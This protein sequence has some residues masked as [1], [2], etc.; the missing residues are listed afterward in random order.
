MKKITK[1]LVVALSLALLIGAVVG[2]SASATETGSEK[3]VISYN[4]SYEEN[5][6]LYFAVDANSVEDSKLLTANVYAADGSVLAEGITTEE[7]NKDLY[8]TKVLEDED[9]SNDG[10][11]V[12]AWIVRTPGIA[13]KD[14][15][16]ELTVKVYYGETADENTVVETFTYSVAEYFLQRLYKDGIIDA[17]ELAEGTDEE[18][19]AAKKA[20]SQKKLYEASLRYGAAAQKVLTDDTVLI[21]DLIYIAGAGVDSIWDSNNFLTLDAG[22]Y[23]VK[24]YVDGEIVNSV[25]EGGNFSVANSAVITKY[26]AKAYEAPETAYGFENQTEGAY[27]YSANQGSVLVRH[28]NY[29]SSTGSELVENIVTDP[30]TGNKYYSTEKTVGGG[31]TWVVM[32]RTD[33]EVTGL[34]TFETKIRFSDAKENAYMRFYKG[35]TVTSPSNG[36]LFGADT[37]DATNNRNVPFYEDDAGNVYFDTIYVGKADTWFTLRLVLE[38]NTIHVYSTNDAGVLV[39][40]DTFSKRTAW[41]DLKDCDSIT[42]MD[43]KAGLI[44]VDLDDMH[45]GDELAFDEA[46]ETTAFNATYKTVNEISASWKGT[47]NTV[48]NI[49]DNSDIVF[50]DDIKGDGRASSSSSAAYEE[51]GDEGQAIYRFQKTAASGHSVSVSAEIMLDYSSEGKL[52]T[53]TGNYPEFR[54]HTSG[55][56]TNRIGWYY[57]NGEIYL[58]DV[59]GTG[60]VEG[61]AAT[62]T[63]GTGAAL[64]EWFKVTF[65]YTY[66]PAV[67]E[68]IDEETQE[69]ITPAVA[70]SATVT[71]QITNASGETVTYNGKTS[72]IQDPASY[73]M[74]FSVIPTY[75]F[76]GSFGI[77]NV[78][79]H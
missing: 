34:L 52:L 50:V 14:F 35:R 30:E 20:V 73:N 40:R 77:R 67:A 63:V 62:Q 11:A 16:D 79:F 55:K 76:V 24:S 15:A 31:Q 58:Y 7:Y 33:T 65:T 47:L 32:Q 8:N 12:A 75:A 37:S 60:S 44:S 45:F 54:L 64:G 71:I 74:Y 41:A 42:I 13:A 61:G 66:T 56:K 26:D 28:Y 25:V 59:L 43:N 68:V 36:T 6:H 69:V 17:V 72:E 51:G 10:E 5:T 2:V 22:I 48:K 19:A 70:E 1:F 49:L 39:Y 38:G 4:V 21:D 27:S 3:W 29:G 53:T 78:V 9:E 23:E 57:D 46:P 18:I